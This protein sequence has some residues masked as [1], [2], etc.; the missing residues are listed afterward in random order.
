MGLRLKIAA[1]LLL[2]GF[3]NRVHWLDSGRGHSTIAI[4]SVGVRVREPGSQSAAPD[5]V[6]R[7]RR[8]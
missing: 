8:R 3:P 4:G 2:G 7:D 6:A 5:E 1:I